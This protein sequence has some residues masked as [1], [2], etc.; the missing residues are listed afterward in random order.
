MSPAVASTQPMRPTLP[1]AL[2]EVAAR[3][4]ASRPASGAPCASSTAASASSTRA[5]E[6]NASIRSAMASASSNRLLASS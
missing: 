5:A 3:R 1:S 2:H 6:M 4:H